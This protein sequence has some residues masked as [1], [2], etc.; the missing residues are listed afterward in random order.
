MFSTI[1]TSEDVLMV[2]IAIIFIITAI[3]MLI[4]VGSMYFQIINFLAKKE[5]KEPVTLDGLFGKWYKGMTNAVPIENEKA[6]TLHHNYDGIRELDNHL[7]PWWTA[8]F[9]ITLIFGAVYMGVY[10]IWGMSPLQDDEYN[11]ELAIATKQ[12][13]EFQAKNIAKIDENSAKLLVTDTKELEK[14]KIIYTA[15]CVACHGGAGEGGVGPNLTDEYW[16][17]GDGNLKEV[18]KIVKNGVPEKGMIAW[19]TQLKPDQIQAVSNF[20]LSMKGTNPPNGKAPQ[21]EKVGTAKADST[22]ASL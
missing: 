7:P 9:V 8:L 17:H 22:M 11:D 16:V 6:I 21:G 13:E 10:H 5:G 18:F 3:I 20:I 15:N 2:V 19:K 1:K 4:I 12:I 14:G